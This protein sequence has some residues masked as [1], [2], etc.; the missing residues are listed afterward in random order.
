MN[1]HDKLFEAMVKVLDIYFQENG[2]NYDDLAPYDKTCFS[3]EQF[4]EMID[5][6]NTD[7]NYAQYL[8]SQCSEKCRS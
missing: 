5:L 2:Y 4:E 8:N 6:T 7:F 1:I 3:R